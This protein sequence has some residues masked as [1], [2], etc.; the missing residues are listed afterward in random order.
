LSA[1]AHDVF[2]FSCNDPAIQADE[3]A[4]VSGE[5]GFPVTVD[6]Q[7]KVVVHVFEGGR[8]LEIDSYNIRGLYTNQANGKSWGL[9]DSGP[10]IFYV[11]G[12]KV[13]IAITGRS[14]T[15]SGVIGRV[16]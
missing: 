16:V 3:A 4:F 5:C 11:D 8:A 6:L 15:G 1:T 2:H 10:D 14:T 7:G 13:F 9:I 12:A